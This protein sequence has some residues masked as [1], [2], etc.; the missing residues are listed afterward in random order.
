MTLKNRQHICG[1]LQKEMFTNNFSY[2]PAMHT[3]RNFRIKYTIQG[4]PEA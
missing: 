1:K 4:H 2:F 3:N